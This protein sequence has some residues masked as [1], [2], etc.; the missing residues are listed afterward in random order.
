MRKVTFIFLLLSLLSLNACAQWYIFPGKN[1]QKQQQENTVV[2]AKEMPESKDAPVREETVPTE[3]EVEIALEPESD[4]YAFIALDPVKVALILPLQA[5]GNPSANFYEMYSGALMAVKD[6]ASKGSA[7]ELNVFDSADRMTALNAGILEDNDIILGPVSTD[8]LTKLLSVCPA[9]KMLI[10][11]LE[12]KAQELADSLN[13]IQ[14]PSPWTCQY[15]EIADWISSELRFNDR[16][17]LIKDEKGLG[18]QAQ[19]LIASLDAKGVKYLPVNAIS[20]DTFPKG[21]PVRCIIASDRDDFISSAIRTLNTFASTG[22][23]SITLYGTSKTRNAATDIKVLHNLDTHFTASYHIDYDDPKVKD[24]ILR[25]R[26]LYNNEPGSFAYQGYDT[27]RY[28]L[29]AA[30]TYGKQWYKKL[31]EYTQK[32]LQAD[33]KFQEDTARTGNVNSAARRIRLNKDLSTFVH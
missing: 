29:Q 3:E 12:P 24:F 30:L 31:P 8:D 28:F 13:M 25:Y 33:F 27:M 4:E 1:G 15:T 2:K 26:A 20:E 6:L 7:I 11:P 22:N 16:I 17:I 10:S 23:C 14:A 5:N 18:E 9:D 21:N 19:C 32:G